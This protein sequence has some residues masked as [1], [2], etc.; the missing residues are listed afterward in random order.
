MCASVN[1]AAARGNLPLLKYY[2]EECGCEV[3]GDEQDTRDRP[4]VSACGS[5]GP[6]MV[7]ER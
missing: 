6:C 2:I 5:L 4:L 3:E 1:E 7:D